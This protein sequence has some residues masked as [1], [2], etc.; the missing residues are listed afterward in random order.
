MT[1]EKELSFTFEYIREQFNRLFGFIDWFDFISATD[2]LAK[3]NFSIIEKKTVSGMMKQW[4]EH[5]SKYFESQSQ[6]SIA[7]DSK[8]KL[9]EQYDKAIKDF[10]KRLDEFCLTTENIYLGIVRNLIRK[11]KNNEKIHR[12][13]ILLE[14]ALRKKKN[15]IIEFQTKINEKFPG[16]FFVSESN[17]GDALC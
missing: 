14:D 16:Q 1:L 15:Q 5:V 7:E 9:P 11:Y 10:S 8:I 17:L 13:L 2:D 3:C 6:T 12:N 4:S